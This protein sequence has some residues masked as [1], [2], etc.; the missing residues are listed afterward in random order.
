MNMAPGREATPALVEAQILRDRGYSVG[1]ISEITGLSRY[2]VRNKTAP[3]LPKS[4]NIKG[5]SLDTDRI[6]A[7]L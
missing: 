2:E 6:R 1:E 4:A 3:R 5:R 7:R